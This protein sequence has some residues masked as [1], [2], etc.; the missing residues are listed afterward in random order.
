MPTGDAAEDIIGQRKAPVDPRILKV[1][2]VVYT[3][4]YTNTELVET[5]KPVSA[6]PGPSRDVEDISHLIDGRS[7]VA[8]ASSRGDGR[9]PLRIANPPPGAP[10]QNHD[11]Q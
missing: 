11:D 6:Y 4:L 7:L 9:G 5:M 8:G 1:G 2:D 10:K 3:I